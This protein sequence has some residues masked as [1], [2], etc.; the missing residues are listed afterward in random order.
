MNALRVAD[1]GKSRIPVQGPSMANAF[2]PGGTKCLVSDVE[3]APR[4]GPGGTVE[5]IVSPTDFCHRNSIRYGRVGQSISLA[6]PS[7]RVLCPKGW[8]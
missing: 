6:I 8:L 3:N 1:A 4:P 5:V 2:C 7:K